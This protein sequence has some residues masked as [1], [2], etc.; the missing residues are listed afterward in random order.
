MILTSVEETQKFAKD[1]LGQLKDKSVIALEGS[2]G[3]GKTTFVQGLAKSL[4]IKRRV[5]SPT[6]VFLRSYKLENQ[7]F[8]VFHHFDLY[9]CQTL[10]EVKSTGL[11]EI[12]L[13]KNCLVAIEWPEIAKEILPEN[14]VWLKFKKIDENT[15]K[16]EI[17]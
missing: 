10:E 7:P 4:G 15:R 8:Q 9:R 13:D 5:L 3:A 14:T 1:F 17:S 2:L 12:L 11:E 16:I 6:F